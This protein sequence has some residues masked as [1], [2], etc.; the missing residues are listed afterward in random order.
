M[1]LS[2]ST[3]RLP[4]VMTAIANSPIGP[5]PRNRA[6]NRSGSGGAGRVVTVAGSASLIPFVMPPNGS[7]LRC[8]AL[9]KDSFPNLRAPPASSAC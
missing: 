6:A 5:K 7:R 4:A 8:G 1:A 3:R 2:G 9:V